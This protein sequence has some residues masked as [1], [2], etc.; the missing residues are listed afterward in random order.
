MNRVL[1]HLSNGFYL[2]NYAGIVFGALTFSHENEQKKLLFLYTAAKHALFVA[3]SYYIHFNKLPIHNHIFLE[4]INN[5]G[6]F[7]FCFPNYAMLAIPYIYH[8][9]D[10]KK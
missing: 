3:N 9:K 1:Y 6:A 8:I 7:I 4:F 5:L 2:L 10:P